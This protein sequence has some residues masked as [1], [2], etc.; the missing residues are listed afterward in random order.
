MDQE[1]VNGDQR[2][3]ALGEI[4][5][6]FRFRGNFCSWASFSGTVAHV[7]AAPHRRGE[8]EDGRAGLHP[9]Q[10]S[11]IPPRRHR[12]LHGGGRGGP[13]RLAHDQKY[14]EVSALEPPLCRGRA[15]TV[16]PLTRSWS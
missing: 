10:L 6:Y 3:N 12:H 15:T 4:G 7:V 2:W 14:V 16:T 11:F 5:E 8:E 13:V 1:R 9:R